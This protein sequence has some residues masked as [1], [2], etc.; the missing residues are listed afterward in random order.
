MAEVRI[1]DIW[2]AKKRISSIVSNSPLIQS[3]TLSRMTNKK[4]YLKLETANEVGAFK[5]RGAA[6][7]IL[8]L[9]LDVQKRGVT[10]FSTGNHGLAVAYVATLL[11]IKPIICI[12]NR[13]PEAKVK[14]LQ[15]YGAELEVIGH[16][17]DDAA[18]HCEAL[19][20]KYN[21]TV[22]PPFDDREVIAG[23]GTIGLEILE[24]LPQVD[25]CL[26]PLSGG[27]LLSGVGLALKSANEGTTITGISVDGAS[28]MAESIK[29]G[30]PTG[31][32]EKDTVADSLLG[33]IGSQNKFTLSIVQSV[34][35]ELVLLQ[36]NSIQKGLS[37]LFYQEK[38]IVEGA[39]AVGAGA[40][41]DKKLKKIGDNVVLII[42]GNNVDVSTLFK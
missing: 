36:E 35:D 5:L 28:A 39:A 12:S 3:H 31:V 23:Q 37:H 25:H 2:K 4:V 17:Q 24:D 33:G 14:Q 27:G 22:I 10:T 20:K 21:M 7:K 9:P 6:N 41:L 34:M 40:L 8:S 26:V 32:P 19:H 15:Q 18:R 16:S 11:G 13:V 42:S 1:R 29:K 30:H 38:L